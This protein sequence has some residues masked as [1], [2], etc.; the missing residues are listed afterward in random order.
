MKLKE[1]YEEIHGDYNEI[2]TRLMKEERI[3]KFVLKLLEKNPLNDLK[4]KID[5]RNWQD[6]FV[7]AHTLKGLS[8][9]LSFTDFTEK[10]SDLTEL[11]RYASDETINL[12]QV[13]QAYSIVKANYENIVKAIQKYK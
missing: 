13:N 1:F 11:L 12:E 8:L 3:E 9:N 10:V 2:L 5:Q 6:A 4:E 7:C